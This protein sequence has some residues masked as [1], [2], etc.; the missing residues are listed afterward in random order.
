MKTKN[1]VQKAV[2]RSAAVIASFILISLTV[3][4]QDFWKKLL[5][6]SS[7]NEIAL[8]M[9]ENSETKSNSENT[10][11]FP[12]FLNEESDEA[13]QLEDWMLNKN[14]FEY[15]TFQYQEEQEQGLDVEDWMLNEKCFENLHENEPELKVEN[16]MTSDKVWNI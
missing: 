14:N 9:T 11:S 16:W 5:T 6:N 7:F 8:A 1:N 3:S 13:L 10:T 12:Y 4:A 2:L 15:S